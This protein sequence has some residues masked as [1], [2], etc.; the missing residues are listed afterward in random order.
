MMPAIRLDRAAA[1]DH[2]RR[3]GDGHLA[4]C[5]SGVPTVYPVD[6]RILNERIVFR[7]S[8]G[9]LVE[10]LRRGIAIALEVDR[11]TARS[12][13]S[14]IV[15][16]VSRLVTEEADINRF[17]ELQWPWWIA[18]PAY[19]YIEMLIEDVSGRHLERDD[20]PGKRSPGQ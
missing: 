6:Y 12:A 3:V 4:L 20:V 19:T 13:W 15:S 5:L 18:S 8:T 16:G 7:I 17:D 11:R 9:S 14:V 10:N 2:L 1:L